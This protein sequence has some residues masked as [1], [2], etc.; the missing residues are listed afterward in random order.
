MS[1]I[2][3]EQ[4]L[5]LAPD[6][7]A[8]QAGKKLAALK[9]WKNLGRT[10]TALWG[11]CQGSALYQVRVDLNGMAVKCSCP[12]RKLPC[13]HGLGLILLSVNQVDALAEAEPPEW[14]ASWLAKRAAPKETAPKASP[15]A[16]EK[17]AAS[18]A[19]TAAKREKGVSDGL[20]TLDLWLTDLVRNG[21][22][23]LEGKPTSFWEAQAARMTDAKA[24]GVATRLRRIAGIPGASDDWPVKLLGDLGRLS[25]LIQAYRRQDALDAGLREDVRQLIGWTLTQEELAARGEHVSDRWTVLGQW[26]DNQDRGLEQRT[27]LLG[28]QSGRL[29]LILQYSFANQPF[30]ESFIPGS[31][32][33]AELHVYPGAYPLRAR[34]AERASEPVA[35]HE[36]LPG[37][38][39]VDAFLRARAEVAAR[40]PWLERL[41]CILRDV[42]PVCSAADS[43][44]IRDQSGAGLPLAGSDHWRLL[45]LSGGNP[46]DVIGEWDGETLLPLGMIAEGIYTPL[47]R[48]N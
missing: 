24:P 1:T 32:F 3:P 5:A 39:S 28:E 26:V 20:D 8:A 36:R 33:D 17:A 13:K 47:W 25:L 35:A 22:S 21:I 6:V 14:V 27:W 45:A 15:I 34:V 4:A 31:S 43:W 2:T 10:A 46:V 9:H 23:A 18:A 42:T 41:A 11:E 48:V 16:P 7:S 44:W 29:A 12:S 37:S 38:E 19:K 40:Q 30:P